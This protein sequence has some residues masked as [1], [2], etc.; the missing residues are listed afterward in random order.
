MPDCQRCPRLCAARTQIVL[1]TV[2]KI[3][4]GSLLCI[5]EAPGADEDRVG[6]GFV[7]RAGQ[8][9]RQALAQ[10]GLDIAWQVGFANVVRCRPPHNDRPTAAEIDACAPH[11]AHTIEALQPAAILAVGG[12]AAAIFFGK[13]PLA[14]LVGMAPSEASA[15]MDAHAHAALRPLLPGWRQAFLRAV[16]PMP[17]TS[18]LAWNR[19]SPFS[20]K[21]WKD[22][23]TD[24]IQKILAHLA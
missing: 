3:S 17:H 1:P 21:R 20:G 10:A 24:Q 8:V 23:G 13:K 6:A 9:L 7:G 4:R 14:E 15:H 18:G 19:P 22:V 16:V 11:L 12:T 5:G 2:P